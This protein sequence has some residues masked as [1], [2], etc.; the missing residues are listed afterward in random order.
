MA[1][2]ACVDATRSIDVPI[3][4]RARPRPGDFALNILALS[5]WDGHDG[6]VPTEPVTIIFGLPD[7]DHV[8]I[9]VVSD[10]CR[11]DDSPSDGDRLVTTVKVSVGGFRGAA[12]AH[13]RPHDLRDFRLALQWIQQSQHDTAWLES[14]DEWVHLR[15]TRDEGSLEMSGTIATDPDRSNRLSFVLPEMTRP[16]SRTR[17]RGFF[18]WRPCSQRERGR[19]LESTHPLPPGQRARHPGRLFP[20]NSF[21]VVCGD[22]YR[23]VKPAS[24]SRTC[25]GRR[26]GGRSVSTNNAP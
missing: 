20:S 13:L 22:N 25:A 18:I 26:I 9:S 8:T 4:S 19:P 3:R 12:S 10:T 16:T 14:Q 17:S 11:D 21:L 15:L 23:N 6:Q 2:Q 1:L 5:P 24:R 7:S